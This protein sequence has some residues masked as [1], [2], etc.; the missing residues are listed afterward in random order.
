MEGFYLRSIFLFISIFSIIITSYF[1]NVETTFNHVKEN[2]KVINKAFAIANSSQDTNANKINPSTSYKNG[3]LPLLSNIENHKTANISL[4]SNSMNSSFQINNI[5][6]INPAD[7][8]SASSLPSTKTVL[9]VKGAALLRDKAFQPN[10]IIIHKEDSI[11]WKNTDDVVHSITSGSNFSSSDRGK[12]F[13]S[14]LLGDTYTHKF[15]NT[16][17]FN[18]FCQIHP[19]MVGEIIVK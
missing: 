3:T 14:G 5:S 2:F 9:I 8:H 11:T 17:K 16:G 12:E 6:S 13:D 4:S 10:P 1:L 19:T 18:Y 7:N 15:M